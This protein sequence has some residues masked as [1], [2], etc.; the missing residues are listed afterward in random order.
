MHHE[1]HT[2]RSLK[3]LRENDKTELYNTVPRLVEQIVS[4]IH[5]TLD[6]SFIPSDDSDEM[7]KHREKLHHREGIEEVTEKLTKKY[8]EIYRSIILQEATAHVKED[9]HSI[10]KKSD[11]QY[12]D[13]WPRWQAR[14]ELIFNE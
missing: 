13:F 5:S 12:S 3:R 2:K 9:M 14:Y 10:P 11:Y 1:E 7:L 8:G 6:S 4:E